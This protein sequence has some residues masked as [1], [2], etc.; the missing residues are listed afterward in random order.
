MKFLLKSIFIIVVIFISLASVKSDSVGSECPFED[1]FCNVNTKENNSL[2]I[3]CYGN[4]VRNVFPKRLNNNQTYIKSLLLVSFDIKTI[5]D[6]AF[7]NLFI[8]YL[9]FNQ[10]NLEKLGK[11]TFRGIKR[12]TKLRIDEHKLTS[13][14]T[15]A[16]DIIANTVTELDLAN[17]ALTNS[18]FNELKE[19]FKLNK[20]TDLNLSGNDLTGFEIAWANA[21]PN[22]VT[23]NMAKNN[24]NN[25]DENVFKTLKQLTLLDISYNHFYNLTQVFYFIKPIQSTLTSLSLSGNSIENLI[26]F[27]RF[28]SLLYLDLS[29]NSIQAI[30]ENSFSSLKPLIRLILDDNRI[31]KID[32]KSFSAN[33]NLVNLY[34]AKNQLKQAPTITNLDFLR[35]ID[36][37]DQQEGVLFITD[38]SFDRINPTAGLSINLHGDVITNY[39]YKSFCSMSSDKSGIRNIDMSYYSAVLLN[40]CIMKQL[41]P[42]NSIPETTITIESTGINDFDYSKVCNCK[43]HAF[44]KYYKIRLAGVCD[45]YTSNCN[46][47]FFDDC[48]GKTEFMCKS[49][50]TTAQPVTT[51]TTYMP[52]TRTSTYLNPNKASRQFSESYLLLIIAFVNLIKNF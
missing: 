12:L 6:D 41:S 1:C 7:D 48:A 32:A 30:N 39:G 25:F 46:E 5:P 11:N 20:V 47:T 13:I 31:N 8:E 2:S 40:K 16:F 49:A 33:T 19:F 45:L 22:L 51:T 15:N 26:D 50:E 35:Y 27:P 52:I 28:D 9:Y 3:V 44:L 14:E 4:N 18:R 36:L 29:Q 21:F 23:L 24:L 42:I 17:S 10:N 34:L 38:N 43:T 37:S